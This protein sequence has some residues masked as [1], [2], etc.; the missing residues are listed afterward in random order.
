MSRTAASIRPGAMATTDR[1]RAMSDG[2]MRDVVVT[3]DSGLHIELM[4]SN[5]NT[6]SEMLTSA[7]KFKKFAR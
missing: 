4:C 5:S 2:W 6:V 1:G 3:S 7:N